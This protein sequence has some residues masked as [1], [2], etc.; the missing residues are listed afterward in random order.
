MAY[1]GS[2]CVMTDTQIKITNIVYTSLSFLSFIA[3]FLSLILNQC[4]GYR[5][6]NKYQFDPIGQM[7]IFA[8]AVFSTFEAFESFQ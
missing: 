2:K 6:K 1:N 4:Q 8:L 7:F 5:Y 3:G